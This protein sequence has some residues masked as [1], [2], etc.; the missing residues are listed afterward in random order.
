MKEQLYSILIPIVST[1]AGV[2]ASVSIVAIIKKII[3]KA[4]E[5]F[6][7]KTLT[8]KIDEIS[9]NK[10]LKEIKEEVVKVKHE[11]LEMRGKRK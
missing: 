6:I 5:S 7:D 4:I 1:V 8:P 2:F 9:T 10:Q 11:I 3:K